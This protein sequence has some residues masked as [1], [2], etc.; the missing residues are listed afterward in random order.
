M[1]QQHLLTAIASREHPA[2]VLEH[3]ALAPQR[4]QLAALPG[5]SLNIT[6]H[7]NNSVL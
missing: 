4:S 1:L 6:V 2:A 5:T 7:F 3:A